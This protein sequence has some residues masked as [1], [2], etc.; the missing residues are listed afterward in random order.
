[1]GSISISIKKLERLKKD[2]NKI[3][4]KLD[5]ARGHI[6]AKHG[7]KRNPF[8]KKCTC[9][10][11]KDDEY[12]LIQNTNCPAHGKETRESIKKELLKA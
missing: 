1:M 2:I 11:S 12:G 6:K 8:T 4:I 9:L 7:N 5:L 10:W 3:I